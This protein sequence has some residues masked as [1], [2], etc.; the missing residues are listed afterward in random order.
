[1]PQ[2]AEITATILNSAYWY[3][4]GLNHYQA[5][6]LLQQN[7]G[8]DLAQALI[9][10]QQDVSISQSD[11]QRKEYEKM[12]AEWEKEKQKLDDLWKNE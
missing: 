1:M 3:K 8:K 11:A 10:Q 6:A 12:K 5:G 2:I 4:G 9:R 7:L